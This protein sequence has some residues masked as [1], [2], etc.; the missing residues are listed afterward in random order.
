MDPWIHLGPRKGKPWQ[1]TAHFLGVRKVRKAIK[2]PNGDGRKQLYPLVIFHG[3]KMV[4]KKTMVYYYGFPWV[5]YK[6]IY[7]I[8]ISQSI[9]YPLVICYTLRTGTWPSRN[10]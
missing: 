5:Y 9:I 2:Y 4:Q 10:S 3:L 7:T 6:P 1:E 8:E